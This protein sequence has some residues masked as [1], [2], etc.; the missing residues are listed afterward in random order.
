MRKLL[1]ALLIC[2]LIPVSGLSQDDR[3]DEPRKSFKDRLFLGGNFGLSFGT[4]T[5][6]NVSPLLGYRVS[7]R[8]S[9]G[10]GVVFNYYKF[11]APTFEYSTSIYGPQ[12]FNR[13]LITETIFAQAE[14]QY[15]NAEVVDPFTYE[16][17]RAWANI[18]YLGGGIRQGLGGNGFLVGTLMYDVVGDRNSPYASR[19]MPRV[20]VVFGL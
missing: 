14:Y 4:T 13:F 15:L 11:K 17:N 2:T 5:N 1:Y 12:L 20:G 18:L 9:V 3:D 16:L 10:A 8:Y 19:W 6:I 7:E